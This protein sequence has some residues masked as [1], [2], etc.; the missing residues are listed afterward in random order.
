MEK[1]YIQVF[2][3]SHVSSGL[4]E[5]NDRTKEWRIAILYKE[6]GIG[7]VYYDA[8]NGVLNKKKSSSIEMMK[9]KLNNIDN[10]PKKKKSTD[11]KYYLSNLNNMLILGDSLKE[12]KKLPPNSIDMV[13]TSPPYFNAKTE[14][15]EYLSYDDYLSFM[16]KIIKEVTRVLIPGKFF[17]INSSPV[18]IPRID[19]KHS[20]T[21]YAVP[22]DLHNLFRKNHYEF[23]DD[24][25]WVKP[26]GAG[27]SSGRGRRF[28]ADRN[29]MQY[30]PVPVTE[31]I[32]VYRKQSNK[33]ID[34]FI[35]KHPD[36]DLVNESKV[37]DGYEKTNIW[38]INPAKDRRH[39]A[40][41]PKEL[42]SN[43]IKYYSF[44]ND[45]VLDPFGGLGTTA[46]AALELNRRFVSI[47]LDKNY[48]DET[49]Q[50]FN[51]NYSL[52]MNNIDIK[53]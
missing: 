22:Y 13:F 11:N 49:I 40:I 41:F 7:F 28:S 18:L 29:P 32:M 34:W 46:K 52:F 8:S 36:Q 48:F 53:E 45:V 37:K 33:L 44:K 42:A 25:Y 43:V 38:K 6:N 16:N 12:L 3:S 17:I 1:D 30:K 50:D 10:E 15:S 4:P 47:E 5:Y 26:E 20:S 35:R 23:M 31:N 39:P 21:R 9:K 2:D 19:R 27:W 14:Y 24:I 51:D